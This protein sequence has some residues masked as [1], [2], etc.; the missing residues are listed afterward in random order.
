MRAGWG[1]MLA[2]VLLAATQLAGCSGGGDWGKPGLEEAEATREY[3][4]CREMAATAVRTDADIDQDIRATR[5][6]DWQRGGFSGIG[7][8]QAQEHTRDR[9]ASIIASCMH[10]KGFTRMR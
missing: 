4:D 7:A 5:Q 3:K 8:Q 2:A 6:R 9:A 10:A 1:W